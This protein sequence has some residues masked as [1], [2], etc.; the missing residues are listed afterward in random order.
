MYPTM[1]TPTKKVAIIT[2]GGSGMG[3]AVGKRLAEEGWHLVLVDINEHVGVNAVF[4]INSKTASFVKADVTKFDDQL[5][6]FEQTFEKHGRIDFV[7]AN[8]GVAGATGFSAR[9]DHWPPKPPSL[10][11]QEVNLT[12]VVYTCYLA[13]HYMRRNEV[14]GGVVVM[15][16]SGTLD[17]GVK[18]KEKRL[19]I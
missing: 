17:T 8:A 9:C 4:E 18:L 1:S 3:L 12:G 13:M 5:A 15:T 16:A 7:F 6:V 11:V 19:L 10:L 2:G 14:P